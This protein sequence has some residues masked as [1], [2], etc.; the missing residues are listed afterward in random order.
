MM[1]QR[2]L[3]LI[4][5]MSL[6]ANAMVI[7]TWFITDAMG[8]EL[9]SPLYLFRNM[10]S[11]IVIVGVNTVFGWFYSKDVSPFVIV[12][13]HFLLAITTFILLG[14]WAEWFPF[15]GGAILSVSLIYT[16]I[17]IAI[18]LGHYLYWKNKIDQMNNK[19]G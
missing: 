12:G 7:V 18:W 10:V 4:L 6:S 1:K 13:L 19:L 9:I 3:T 11:A 2:L 15:D 14:I 17:F 8:Y 5:V 16:V